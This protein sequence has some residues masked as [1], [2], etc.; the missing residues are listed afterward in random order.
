MEHFGEP[1][2]GST[3]DFGAR[4]EP[5]FHRELLDWLAADFI[6]SGWSVKHLHRVILLSCAYQQASEADD[7][8]DRGRGRKRGGSEARNTTA[9]PENKL[10][11][12]FPRRRLD[13]E[14]MRD[15]LLFIS[16]RMDQTMGGPSV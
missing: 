4:S 8:K 10:L 11:S 13:F 16:G 9:D 5:P 3:T 7:E 6:R 15:S 1:L 14:A 12:R 2:A